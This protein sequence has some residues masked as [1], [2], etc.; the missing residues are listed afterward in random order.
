M[1][2]RL[3]LLSLNSCS[4]SEV[5]WDKGVWGRGGTQSFSSQLVLFLAASSF[6]NRALSLLCQVHSFPTQYPRDLPSFPFPAGC[7][8]TSTRAKTTRSE[9]PILLSPLSS[10]LKGPGSRGG[11]GKSRGW[12]E[13]RTRQCPSLPQ[14]NSGQFKGG[15]SSTPNA[16][17][18]HIPSQRVQNTGGCSL[19]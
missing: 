2:F 17:T 11:E 5:W 12:S 6:P 14:D 10:S 4:V 9:C 13:G 16:S 3:I 15:L 8:H 18:R 19:P 7:L 1:I